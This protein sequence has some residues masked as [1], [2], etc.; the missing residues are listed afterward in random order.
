[1]VVRRGIRGVVNSAEFLRVF[2][3]LGPLRK[4]I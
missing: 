1:M 3:I 4:N 2:E